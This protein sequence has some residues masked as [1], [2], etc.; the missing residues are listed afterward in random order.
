MAAMAAAAA[1]T[2]FHWLPFLPLLSDYSSS[3]Y[4]LL[5]DPP[6]YDSSVPASPASA[7]RN[8][9]VGVATT[10]TSPAPFRLTLFARAACCTRCTP[11]IGAV[12]VAAA[13][14]AAVFPLARVVTSGGRQTDRQRKRVH[15]CVCVCRRNQMKKKR[16]RKKGEPEEHYG[17]LETNGHTGL[18]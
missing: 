6:G 10:T 12:A 18:C 8:T 1:D 9:F 3:S 15:V 7:P 2:H 4:L 14:A 5:N 16:K 13:A 17:T 11:V